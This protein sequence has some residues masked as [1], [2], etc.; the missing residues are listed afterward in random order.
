MTTEI[1]LAVRTLRLR[2]NNERCR[3]KLTIG[4]DI[5]ET[6][7]CLIDDDYV[8]IE[9]FPDLV[10]IRNISEIEMPVSRFTPDKMCWMKVAWED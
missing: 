4:T 7:E 1:K 5:Y 3:V 6:D 8:R 10:N 2:L 9:E